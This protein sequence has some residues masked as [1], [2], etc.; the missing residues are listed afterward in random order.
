MQHQACINNTVNTET[1]N[2]VLPKKNIY[3]SM[4]MIANVAK[5]YE[6]DTYMMY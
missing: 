5:H 3:L 4:A 1:M 2:R 6:Q